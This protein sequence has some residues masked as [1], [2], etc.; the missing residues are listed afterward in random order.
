MESA[1]AASGDQAA[2]ATGATTIDATSAV[3]GPSEAAVLLISELPR[4]H[5][6]RTCPLGVPEQ[7][8]RG[9]VERRALA[10][11]GEQL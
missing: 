9:M 5:D 8:G 7:A 1:K 11:R 10:H 3:K 6:L 2:V 4:G